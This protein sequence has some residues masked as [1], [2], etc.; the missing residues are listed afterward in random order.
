MLS[1]DRNVAKLPSHSDVL[2]SEYKG[3]Q[4]HNQG[5]QPPIR[6]RKNEG[7]R[8]PQEQLLTADYRQ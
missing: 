4:A 1:E 3:Y 2:S 5:N 7:L 8:A 6:S